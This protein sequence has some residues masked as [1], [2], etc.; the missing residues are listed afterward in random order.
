MKTWE[1]GLKKA[2]ESRARGVVPVIERS[3]RR[4]T[5]SLQEADDYIRYR[6]IEGP[7]LLRYR[8]AV[9]GKSRPL[10][11]HAFCEECQGYDRN[12]AKN[13]ETRGCPLWA[14]RPGT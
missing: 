4:E 13:C 5:A 1:K 7:Y 3:D 12:A 11:I 14:W 10:A 8:K 6:E 2:H 9:A